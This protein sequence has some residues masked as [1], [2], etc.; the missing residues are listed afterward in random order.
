MKIYRVEKTVID[1]HGQVYPMVSPLFSTKEKA[2]DFINRQIDVEKKYYTKVV[3]R[4]IDVCGIK[5]MVK[6]FF[7]NEG[8]CNQYILD[9]V[10]VH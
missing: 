1:E 6:I 9:D 2:D 5:R 3:D 10:E 4:V 7:G 8:Y